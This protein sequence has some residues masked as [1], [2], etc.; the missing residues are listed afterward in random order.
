[1]QD[2]TVT[3]RVLENTQTVKKSATTTFFHLIIRVIHINKT[4]FS[5]K[6]HLKIWLHGQK[7]VPLQPF[8]GMRG[9]QKSLIFIIIIL[10]HP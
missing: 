6:K 1:M 8:S 7:Y 10:H 2:C 4:L 9:L 5:D 3:G